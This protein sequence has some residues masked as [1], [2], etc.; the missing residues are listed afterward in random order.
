MVC[1]GVARTHLE[2][3]LDRGPGS[4]Q[5]AQLIE[6]VTEIVVGL[7]IVRLKFQGAMKA[8]CSFLHQSAP[9]GKQTELKLS[10]SVRGVEPKRSPKISVGLPISLQAAEDGSAEDQKLGL[11]GR[12]AKSLR[13]DIHRLAGLLQAIQQPREV[14]PPLDVGRL[15]LEQVA[16][17][18][19]RFS[20][21]RSGGEVRR[22]LKPQLGLAS[23][24]GGR[25][26]IAL[27][28]RGST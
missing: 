21:K 13:Q 18:S 5:I 19:D 17:R 25:R 14:Q 27:R 3:P 20:R 1:L 23:I 22:L 11:I 10:R 9:P 2:R 24:P 26:C 15:Q 7:G 16:V 6:R 8:R 28:G 12:A 4:R